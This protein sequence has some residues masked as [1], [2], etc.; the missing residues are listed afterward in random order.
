MIDNNVMIKTEDTNIRASKRKAGNQ[1]F[2]SGM[3]NS[4]SS[5][6]WQ[7]IVASYSYCSSCLAADL[8]S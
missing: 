7:S 6:D 4:S 1:L 8:H 2:K 3:L 5:N